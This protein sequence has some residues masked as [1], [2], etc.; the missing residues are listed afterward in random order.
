MRVIALLIVSLTMLGARVEARSVDGA[1][2]SGRAAHRLAVKDIRAV[3]ALVRQTEP[4]AKR[5]VEID[6]ISPT[7]LHVYWTQRRKGDED[8]AM[9]YW[10]KGRWHYDS[11]FSWGRAF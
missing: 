2:I 4:A 3:I 8:Y 1:T 6:A 9:V 5:I 10:K 11:T 7:D